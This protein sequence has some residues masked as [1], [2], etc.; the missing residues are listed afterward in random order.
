MS[1]IPSQTLIPGAVSGSRVFVKSVS[2]LYA[3]DLASGKELWRVDDRNFISL[4]AVTSNQVFVVK[5]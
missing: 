1:N 3:L 4:P 2:S 5:G